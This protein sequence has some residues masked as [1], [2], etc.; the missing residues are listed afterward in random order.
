MLLGT[1]PPPPGRTTFGCGEPG[2]RLFDPA[3]GGRLRCRL[4]ARWFGAD[5]AGAGD[6]GQAVAGAAIR[7]AL[8]RVR[9]ERCRDVAGLRRVRVDRDP[10][11]ARGSE[12]GVGAG[13]RGP[14]GGGGGRPAARPLGGVPAQA[15]GDDHDGP[16]PVRGADE[17]AR[18][19]LPRAA[20]LRPV[21]DR[22]GR[23]GR[24]RH[25]LHRGERR[26]P[27]NAGAPGGSAGG[28]RAVRV[29][30]L[31][32]DHARTA[33]GRRRRRAVRTG[34]D[35][36]R[37]RHQF[38]ALRRGDSRDRQGRAAPGARRGTPAAR[39]RPPRRLA[40]PADPPDPA[41]AAVQRG[42]GQRPDHGDP[43]ADGGPHARAPRVRALAVRAR[44]RGALPRRPGRFPA[45][46]PARRP[47][48]A[49]P[50]PVRG[51]GFSRVLADRAGV[52]RSRSARAGLR[53]RG[54]TGP[55]HLLRRLQPGPG[56]LPPRPGPE[57][58]GRPR[59]VRL[60]DR[61]QN[62]HRHPDRPLGPAGHRHHAPHRDRR[63]GLADPRHPLLLPRSAARPEPHP[64]PVRTHA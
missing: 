48:R 12:R 30:E 61:D 25:H 8:G 34:G 7:V 22:V 26:L 54:R 18:R 51:R 32:R 50:N 11:V 27:E 45:R 57:R 2:G 46:P 1:R 37:Q 53:R 52:R 49:V 44:V 64:E 28:Q 40:L 5:G 16:H 20:H 58:S 59:P 13:G 10:G 21:A 23:G 3:T 60:V 33:T 55:D 41:A 15:V 29:H 17:R 31:D 47:L 38:P 63:R 14:G 36:G 62:R 43:A 39:R 6:A 4:D 24:G 42:P 56:H 35:R 9:G 19:V